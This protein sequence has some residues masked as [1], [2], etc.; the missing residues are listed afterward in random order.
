MVS[1]KRQSHDKV[2]QVG[3][4]GT[5]ADHCIDLYQRDSSHVFVVITLEG[6]AT[7]T[8]LIGLD[9]SIP[10]ES[11]VAA[12][13]ILVERVCGRALDE[14]RH[15]LEKILATGDGEPATELA[16]DVLLSARN[17]FDPDGLLQFSFEGVSEALEQP[18]FADPDRLRDVLRAVEAKDVLTGLF[19]PTRHRRKVSITIGDEIPVAE[20]RSCSIVANSYRFGVF[21]GTVGVIGPVRMP[22]PRIMGLVEYTGRLLGEMLENI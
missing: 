21:G 22:Y 14:L 7:R 11:I 3:P 6:G 12:S 10:P 20:L 17:L 8:E 18:E 1:R 5:G 19:E 9:R 13:T 15:D 4:G 16:R 2:I